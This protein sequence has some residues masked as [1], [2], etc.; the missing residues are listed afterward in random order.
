MKIIDK[1]LFSND[2]IMSYIWLIAGCVIGT[3][4]LI[5]AFYL[6]PFKALIIFAGLP[7]CYLIFLKPE[8]DFF[9][10]VFAIPLEM[11][12]KFTGIGSITTISITKILGFL[13]LTT[14]LYPVIIKKKKANFNRECIILSL[15]CLVALTTLLHTSYVRSGGYDNLLFG[16]LN[17]LFSRY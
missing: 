5:V 13:A 6:S 15:F 1:I 14:W 12:G 16:Y 7:V 3:G 4:Y 8:I 9:L 17:V 10:T 11:A 2:R